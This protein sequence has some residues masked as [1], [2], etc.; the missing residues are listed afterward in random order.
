MI[1]LSDKKNAFGR[2]N[3]P[4]IVTR[5]ITSIIAV[6]LRT[7]NSPIPKSAHQFCSDFNH[8]NLG[9]TFYAACAVT[10]SSVA[11]L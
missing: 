5:E 4:H 9:C 10:L 7:R 2:E 8:V 3:L 6:V 11:L 1:K